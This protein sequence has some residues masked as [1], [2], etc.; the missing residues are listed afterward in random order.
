MVIGSKD[1]HGFPALPHFRKWLYLKLFFRWSLVQQ[2]LPQ[3]QKP[4]KLL[5]CA[6]WEP[7]GEVNSASGKV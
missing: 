6:L 1:W 2:V 7:L 3:W 4:G 5:G